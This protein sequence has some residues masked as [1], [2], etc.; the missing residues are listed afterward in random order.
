VFLDLSRS[1]GKALAAPV[2][3]AREVREDARTA[4]RVELLSAVLLFLLVADVLHSSAASARHRGEYL[5]PV[6]RDA[7]ACDALRHIVVVRRRL[8]S[9]ARRQAGEYEDNSPSCVRPQ[10]GL[11]GHLLSRYARV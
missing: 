1:V 3:V 7:Y 4:P 11:L 8:W 5:R 10:L 6:D 2:N 9:C